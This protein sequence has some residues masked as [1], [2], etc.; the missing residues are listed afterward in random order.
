MET[1]RKPLI[2]FVI[3]AAGILTF[4]CS[5]KNRGNDK[6]MVLPAVFGVGS[7]IGS[8]VSVWDSKWSY[9][10]SITLYNDGTA[11]GTIIDHGPSGD[12]R[13]YG[14]GRWCRDN[15]SFA[16]KKYYWTDVLIE[17]GNM[18][19]RFYV[20]PTGGVYAPFGRPVWQALRDDEPVFTFRRR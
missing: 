5:C 15:A 7:W 16:D 1:K 2:L 11:E 13:N 6:E 18:R 20:D 4:F 9:T 10:Y 14:T 8:E 17:T 3:I 12:I 19:H